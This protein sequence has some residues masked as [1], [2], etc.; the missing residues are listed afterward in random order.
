MRSLRTAGS[1]KV[2][3]IVGLIT[4]LVGLSF[5]FG[6]SVSVLSS[7]GSGRLT[8][9]PTLLGLS[10]MIGV[11]LILSG[12]DLIRLRA[13]ARIYVVT[14]STVFSLVFAFTLAAN[15]NSGF[16]T[17]VSLGVA[18]WANLFVVVYFNRERIRKL[19]A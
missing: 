4:I 11:A 15:I 2:I 9:Q 1:N 12:L 14:W 8:S 10:F 19:Y 17:L 16:Q 7:I 18:L 6:V 3:L 5:C 13:W